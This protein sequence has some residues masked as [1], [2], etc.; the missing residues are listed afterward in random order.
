MRGFARRG[1]T[2]YSLCASRKGE[3]SLAV[4]RDEVC[5]YRAIDEG[6]IP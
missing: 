4:E 1:L 2:E 6:G 3:V 5:D